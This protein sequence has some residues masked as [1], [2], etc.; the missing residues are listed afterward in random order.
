VRVLRIWTARYQSVT[1]TANALITSPSEPN[2]SIVI[3]RPPSP[4]ASRHASSTGR[5]IARARRAPSASTSSTS[6]GF[7]ANA[8]R[9]SRIGAKRSFKRASRSFFTSP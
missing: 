4:A 7:A 1:T 6:L 5:A 2:C 8:A 9:R 3:V